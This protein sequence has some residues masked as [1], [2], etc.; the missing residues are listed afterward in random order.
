[1]ADH[2]IANPPS[3]DFEVTARFHAA[4][5]F[6]ESWRD[7]GWMILERGG[8]TIEFFLCPDFDPATSAFGSCFRMDDINGFF[9]LVL[10]AGFSETTTGW[11][12]AHR[13]ERENW[14]MLV[15]A[16]IDPDGPRSAS[17]K[18]MHGR[19]LGQRPQLLEPLS[20]RCHVHRRIPR[21]H[22]GERFRRPI[23]AA[24]RRK[25][26]QVALADAHC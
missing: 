18:R 2:A 4:L 11:P 16:L 13:P 23:V 15:G 21:R 10:A 19:G 14:G 9:E 3:R 7:T 6:A 12:R 20:V 5:G 22:P 24:R 1:M 8:L 25:A 17:S 26:E